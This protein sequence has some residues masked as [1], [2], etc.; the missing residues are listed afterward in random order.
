MLR[1]PE[2]KRHLFKAPFGKLFPEIADILPFIRGHPV[3][4]VG[5]VVTYRLIQQGIIPDIA[6][7]D[8]YSMRLPCQWGPVEFDRCIR[9]RN[10]PATLTDELIQELDGAVAHPPVLIYVEGEEDL[11]VIPL[12]L[13]APEGATILYGQPHKGVVLRTVDAAAK[14]EA[15]RLLSVFIRE[16]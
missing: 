4:T 3:Y 8:G 16:S 11:A 6:I 14:D 2:D 13:A 10:P 7:I 1:L 9:V 12:V 5:D 15:R